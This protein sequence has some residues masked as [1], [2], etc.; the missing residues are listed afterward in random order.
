MTI[1]MNHLHIFKTGT[2]KK[3]DSVEAIMQN[4][5]GAPFV[6]FK[7]VQ[8]NWNICRFGSS[9][10]KGKVWRTLQRRKIGTTHVQISPDRHV[11]GMVIDMKSNQRGGRFFSYLPQ[12]Y[13]IR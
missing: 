3:G 1:E 13:H 9:K 11:I 8:K 7:V 4:E 12:M 2:A 10:I 6:R 5:T